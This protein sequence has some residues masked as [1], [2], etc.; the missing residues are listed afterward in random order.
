MGVRVNFTPSKYEADNEPYS[1][2]NHQRHL[3][4]KLPIERIHFFAF[5]VPCALGRFGVML[6]RGLGLVFN[7]AFTAARKRR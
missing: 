1:S 7:P 3:M 6:L 2:A 4:L 5:R